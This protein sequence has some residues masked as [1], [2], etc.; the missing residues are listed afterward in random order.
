MMMQ[1]G[2]H[3]IRHNTKNLEPMIFVILVRREKANASVHDR[4][5]VDPSAA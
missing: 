1:R 5:S 2:A 3:G 4:T